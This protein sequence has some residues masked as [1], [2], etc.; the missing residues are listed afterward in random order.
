MFRQIKYSITIL[1]LCTFIYSIQAHAAGTCGSSDDGVGTTHATGSSPW[2]ADSASYADVNYCANTAMGSGEI[3]NVPAGTV[4]W[5]S[6]LALTQ[7]ITLVGAGIGNTV[8][9]CTGGTGIS[10]IISGD[11]AFNMSGFTIKDDSKDSFGLF[12]Y[13]SSRSNPIYNLRVHHNRFEGWAYGVKPHGMVYG[14]IYEN[15][16]HNNNCD[17]FPLGSVAMKQAW[18]LFP[19]AA[20]IGSKH[21]LYIEDN[22]STGISTIILASGE[23]ARW[24]YRYNTAEI[25]R[26][27][28]DAHGDTLNYGVVA[29]ELYENTLTT[30]GAARKF[31]DFRGGTGIVFN[32]YIARW[33]WISMKEEYVNEASIDPN[34]PGSLSVNNSYL[35]NN[36]DT[37]NND[38]L[39]IVS[40]NC[41]KCG[42][43]GDIHDCIT[44]NSEWWDDAPEEHSDD[45]DDGD[46][47]AKGVAAGRPGT[48]AD[49]DCYW[50][51]D[52]RKLYRC[53][54]AN[55]WTFIYSPYSYPHPLTFAP[56]NLEILH[57]LTK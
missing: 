51:T 38:A 39:Q 49:D 4:T 8:I 15:Q 5:P 30:D 2:T 14:V 35:W 31:H 9:T 11:I 34:F 32:N 28:F 10:Y 12:I 40:D 56:Q 42:G 48:C 52:T 46:D 27:C 13:N 1:A 18:A 54:G 47:F 55:N 57:I 41:V 23:G 19:G 50:E 44:E 20:N 22:T 33:A 53:V 16:F 24:V 36:V 29:H 43:L 37:S 3:L 25:N 26:Q 45:T 17:L 7:S 21:Y 6:T